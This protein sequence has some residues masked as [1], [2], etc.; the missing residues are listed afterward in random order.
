MRKTSLVREGEQK[1][2]FTT[3]LNYFILL[4]KLNGLHI[5]TAALIGVPAPSSPKYLV[6]ILAPRDHPAA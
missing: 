4:T 3:T 6:K 1:T 5:V 2:A